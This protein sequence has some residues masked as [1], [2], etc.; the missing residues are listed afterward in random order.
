MFVVIIIISL[1]CIYLAIGFVHVLY[2]DSE[3]DTIGAITFMLF[4]PFVWVFLIICYIIFT[5]I[6][7]SCIKKKNYISKR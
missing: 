1:F 6:G 4:W 7:R 3:D 5:F 2:T